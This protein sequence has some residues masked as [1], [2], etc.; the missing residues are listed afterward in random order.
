VKEEGNAHVAADEEI[1]QHRVLRRAGD[2]AGD[3]R[4]DALREPGQRDYER[5]GPKRFREEGEFKLGGQRA[6]A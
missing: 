2:D 5:G 4:A 1:D 6:A 3:A